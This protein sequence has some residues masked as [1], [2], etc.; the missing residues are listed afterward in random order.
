LNFFFNVEIKE[1]QFGFSKDEGYEGT[2]LCMLKNFS[3]LKEAL[4]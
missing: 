4:S 2:C 3:D 1:I